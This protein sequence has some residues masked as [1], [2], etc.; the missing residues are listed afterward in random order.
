MSP[1]GKRIVVFFMLWVFLVMI[2]MQVYDNVTGKGMPVRSAPTQA[3]PAVATP[4]PEGAKLADLQKCVASNP[5]DLNC[6]MQIGQLY[7]RGQQW[8][9]AQVSY[10][11]AVTLDPRSVEALSRLAVVYIHQAEYEKALGTLDRAGTLQ[12]DDPEINLLLGLALSKVDPPR[13]G[14]ALAAWRKVIALAPGSTWAKQ[15]D[16]LIKD[17]GP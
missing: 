1:L 10:E 6:T 8:P 2:V 14:D 17:A 16:T 12:P 13:K 9:Q 15:A 11:R 4:D 7:Y 5:N 3:V